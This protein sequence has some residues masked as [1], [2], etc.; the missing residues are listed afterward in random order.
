MSWGVL[1]AAML[2]GLVGAIVPIVIHLLN[3]T[4]DPVIEWGA[5]QFLELGRQ[6]RRRMR[7]NELLL[8]LAQMALLALVALALARPYWSRR[9]VRV[10]L[11]VNWESRRRRAT[12]C[13]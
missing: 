4:R 11:A 3:R 1:N 6:E 9:R 5:M 13:L 7:L 10:R 12:S 8:M 2:A